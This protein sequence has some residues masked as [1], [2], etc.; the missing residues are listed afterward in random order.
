MPGLPLAD[1]LIRPAD[2]CPQRGAYAAEPASTGTARRPVRIIPIV[3]IN[4]ANSPATGFSDCAACAEVSIVVTP[5]AFSV[6]AVVI[7]IEIG[8]ASRNPFR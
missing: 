6:A 8:T 1:A 3:K 7:I 4:E 2:A 5:L